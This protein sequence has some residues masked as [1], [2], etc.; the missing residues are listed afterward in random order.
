MRKRTAQIP[1]MAAP[2]CCPKILS[3]ETVPGWAAESMRKPLQLPKPEG[4]F[5]CITIPLPAIPPS[6]MP[7]DGNGS[8]L[9]D[10]G[11]DEFVRQVNSAAATILLLLWP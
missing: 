8:A 2:S 9:V 10:I 6:A 3:V 4:S 1:V 7:G 11:A 5:D